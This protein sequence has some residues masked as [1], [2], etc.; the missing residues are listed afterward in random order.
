MAAGL[1]VLV[2]G[3]LQF[4]TWKAHHLD[5]CRREPD[6]SRR[7]PPDTSAAWRLGLR[8][9]LHCGSCCAG[10]M[11]ALLVLGLMDLRTMAVVTAAI[12]A[13]RLLPE[14]ERVARGLG[15]VGVVAG[16]V[17]ILRAAAQSATL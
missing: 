4:T 11:A 13:E 12:T 1:V 14:G 15:V 3:V 10:P 2:A 5:C 7:L 8:L 16:L 6:P 17:L 9:A